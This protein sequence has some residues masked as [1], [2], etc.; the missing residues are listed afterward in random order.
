MLLMLFLCIAPAACAHCAAGEKVQ[1][2]IN[3]F[4]GIC[5]YTSSAED[6]TAF[7]VLDNLFGLKGLH[8]E[9]TWYRTVYLY[10]ALASQQCICRN[11]NY[12]IFFPYGLCLHVLRNAWN[13][14]SLY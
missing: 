14:F 8:M 13:Q 4:E 6:A 3:Y 1:V 11:L 7:F 5:C 10:N 9:L 2:Y 12:G